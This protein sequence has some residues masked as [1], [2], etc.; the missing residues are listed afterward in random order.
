[1]NPKHLKKIVSII[2]IAAALSPSSRV[3][4]KSPDKPRIIA[5]TDGEI[6]SNLCFIRLMN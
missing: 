5:T 2:L 6:E 4:G 3:Y 1:M